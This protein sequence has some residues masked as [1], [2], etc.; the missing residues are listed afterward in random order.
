MARRERYRLIPECPERPTL[1][2]I[3]NRG[4]GLRDIFL[5]P[6]DRL[7]FLSML[8]HVCLDDGLRIHTYCLMTNHF[9]LL[10]EDPRGMISRAM[11]RLQAS[12][13]RYFN[14][15]RG[16]RG[17]GHV[18]GD[19]FFSERVTSG[20]YYDRLVSYILLN[21]VRCAT[22][23]ATKAEDYPWSSVRLHLS[24][25]PSSDFFAQLVDS[26]GGI[27]TLLAG[28]P[29]PSRP[30]YETTR[31]NRFNALLAGE[32]IVRDSAR[33]GRSPEKMSLTLERRHSM[34]RPDPQEQQPE[35]STGSEQV[36]A[37]VLPSDVDMDV[38]TIAYEVPRVTKPFLGCSVESASAAIVR[39]CGSAI[40]GDHSAFNDVI[41]YAFWRF[42][43]AEPQ[44][45]SRCLATTA[46]GV[47]RAV[48][49]LRQ[50]KMASPAWASLLH[51]LEW[52]LRYGLRCAPW[53]A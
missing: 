14:D 21:P 35:Q 32:W 51:R 33:S 49:R 47:V 3:T 44:T 18:F 26:C 36:D 34:R 6:A 1:L 23:L 8:A 42:T 40:P 48:E 10:V 11:L 5:S 13:A 16:K 9:H 38:D 22:P 31:R 45:I 52:A 19:R 12:Y 24:T 2:H 37:T 43:S 27:E 39:V 30:E 4:A 15:C 50:L 20:R 41:C 17:A 46:S 7:I 25:A 53:R 29:A 28:M